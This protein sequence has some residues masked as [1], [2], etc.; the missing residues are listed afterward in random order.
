MYKFLI[1][2]KIKRNEFLTVQ[3]IAQA[4]YPFLFCVYQMIQIE[5]A[6]FSAL[7]HPI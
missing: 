1:K 4:V 2:Y 3:L 5:L 7:D 6:I